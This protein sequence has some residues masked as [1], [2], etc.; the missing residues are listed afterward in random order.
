VKQIFFVLAIVAMAC[1]SA[2][3]VTIETEVTI[4]GKKVAV[5]I[6]ANKVTFDNPELVLFQHLRGYVNNEK[7]PLYRSNWCKFFGFTGDAGAVVGR[8]ELDYQNQDNGFR[9]EV[10]AN[11]ET[12]EKDLG[13]IF[14]SKGNDYHVNTLHCTNNPE[15]NY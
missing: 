13:V 9:S 1:A 5:K 4:D 10:T 14:K 15:Y 12:E 7:Y 3:T 6:A 8:Y 11:G 2:K